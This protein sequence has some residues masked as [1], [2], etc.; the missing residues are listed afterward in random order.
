MPYNIRTRLILMLEATLQTWLAAEGFFLGINLH[1][2]PYTLLK[3]NKMQQLTRIP[4]RI[5]TH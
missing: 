1:T 2:T 4:P 3:C 5:K